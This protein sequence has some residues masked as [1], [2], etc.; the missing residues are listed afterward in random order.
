METRSLLSAKL[1]KI[2]WSDDYWAIANGTLGARYSDTKFFYQGS[3][4]D[5][6]KYVSKWSSPKLYSEGKIDLMSPAEKYDL[7]IGDTQEYKLNIDGQDYPIFGTLNYRMW[8]E[9]AYYY[10]DSGVVETWMGICHG[11]AP[12][13]FMV[14]NPDREVI[15]KDISL[16]KD[17]TFK[18]SDIKALSSLLWAN[19][20]VPSKFIGGRCN[21]KGPSRDPNGRIV[22]PNCL[23]TNPGTFHIALINQIGVVNRSFVLDATFD[24]QVWNQPVYSYRYEY[25]RP[26][27]MEQSKSFTFAIQKI[28][29]YSEDPYKLHRSP[30][31][32]YVIGIALE[33]GYAVEDQPSPASFS[34]LTEENIT[35]VDYYYDLELDANYNIVGG[36]WYQDVHPDFLWMPPRNFVAKSLADPYLP[37]LWEQNHIDLSKANIGQVRQLIQRSSLEGQPL[38]QIVYELVRRSREHLKPSE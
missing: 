5:K 16:K 34:V 28:A 12:A 24:Y 8:A 13:S 26:K 10:R 17:I 3:W 15:V 38:G 35:Y 37:N 33:L 32:K 30:K 9:G 23:D 22:D 18:P 14:S 11:W 2:P 36:E 7:L 1:R 31:A 21:E 27:D 20:K 25:F 4:F 29:D 19:A 6:L